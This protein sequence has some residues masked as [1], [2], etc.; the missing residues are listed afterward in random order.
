MSGAP[1][2]RH[3]WVDAS[4]GVAGDM[5]L[6]ALLDAGA[7]LSTVQTAVDAVVAAT[8]EISVTPT[9][10][11]G[12]RATKA[13][14]S[15]KAADQPHR[16]WRE[17]RARL[18]AA[19]LPAAVR[20]N[21]LA[22]FERLAEAEGHVHGI[23]AEEVEF[24]EVGAWDSIADVVGVCAAL[25]DLGVATVSAGVVAVGSGTT[26][27]A[28]GEVGVPVPAV[29]ALSRG[30]RIRAGGE[31]ELATPTGMALVVTLSERCEDLPEL[32]MTNAGTG[33]GSRDRPGRANV[34]RVLIGDP[35][36]GT[37]PDLA[38]AVVLE[39]NVDDLDPRLWPGV[40]DGLLRA[41]A[42]DAWLTPI[43]MKK[44]RPAHQLSVLAPPE[45][46]AQLRDLVL[47]RTSTLG[48]RQHS[49]EKYALPRGWSSVDVEGAPVLIKVAHRGGEIVQATPEFASV[50]A[51]ARRLGWS[52]AATLAAAERSAAEH[53]LL[54]GRP[55]PADLRATAEEFG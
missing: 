54:P 12:L 29:V 40:L 33:A 47:D 50:A 8:V 22:V 26:S 44:G 1:G 43:L 21:A 39:A 28:H 36:P 24:H 46:V 25:H 45:L 3:A 7:S 31:G 15:L 10:R 35:A 2:S 41:G 27:I 38:E 51:A 5:L 53:D 13:E 23:A 17:V 30:W 19:D 18:R 49:A 37:R 55:V 9:Q 42:S 20:D 16:A 34:T 32:I 11:A 4:A 52:E 14:V 48:V 6:G